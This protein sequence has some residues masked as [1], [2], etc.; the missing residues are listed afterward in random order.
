MYTSID[1]PVSKIMLVDD[2]AILSIGML[3]LLKRLMPGSEV[4]YFSSTAKAA[5]ALKADEYRYLITDLVMPGEDVREFILSSRK[6][7]PQLIIMILSSLSD[8]NLLRDYLAKG[9]DGYLSKSINEHELKQAFEATFSGKK[10]I[11]SD[12]NSKLATSLYSIENTV[13]TKKE[14]EVL[15]L[16]AAGYN[17]KKIADQLFVSPV[18]VMTHRR[19]ILSKLGL[20]SAAELVK[21]AY[22]NNLT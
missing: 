1:V 16:V 17:V 22:D 11:S 19:S 3:E 20:H 9:I 7:Y 6:T 15:R 18:T 5:V 10:Y 12:L 2:H 8:V 13:L 4:N 21:Y 14:L